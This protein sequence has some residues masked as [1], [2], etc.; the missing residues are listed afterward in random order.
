MLSAPTVGFSDFVKKQ[1]KDIDYYLS[2][3]NVAHFEKKS[4][5]GPAV[6]ETLVIFNSMV[7]GLKNNT[8]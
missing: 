7:K 2:K 3:V 1:K 6:F 5:L 8:F 4:K